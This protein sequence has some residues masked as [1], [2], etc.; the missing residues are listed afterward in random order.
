MSKRRLGQTNITVKSDQVGTSSATKREGSWKLRPREGVNRH[1]P[2]FGCPWDVLSISYW[3][4]SAWSSSP[5]CMTG[6]SWSAIPSF[7]WSFDPLAATP[8]HHQ[9]AASLQLTPQSAASLQLT[10]LHH[11]SPVSQTGVPKLTSFEIYSAERSKQENHRLH[12]TLPYTGFTCIKFE[13][14][15]HPFADKWQ[16]N[17]VGP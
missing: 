7:V 6:I 15:E 4:S 16:G 12:T 5:E 11:Q 3:V 9:S 8:L 13:S 14:R 2:D 1:A 17:D 10:P